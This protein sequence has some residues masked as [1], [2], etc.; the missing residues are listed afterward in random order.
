MLKI[1]NGI[2]KLGIYGVEAMMAVN[3]FFEMKQ[4]T[5][6]FARSGPSLLPTGECILFLTGWALTHDFTEKNFLAELDN[7]I[8]WEWFNR[9]DN[10]DLF[11][12]WQM[13]AKLKMSLIEEDQ[14]WQTPLNPFETAVISKVM[15]NDDKQECFS[16]AIKELRRCRS[17]AMQS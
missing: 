12:C 17:L 4:I 16:R 9:K 1:D 8:N 15:N 2:V 11:R 7:L 6:W 14:P 13:L 10:E 3:H 5:C